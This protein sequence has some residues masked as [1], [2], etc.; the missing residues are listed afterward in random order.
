[1]LHEIMIGPEAPIGTGVCK[2]LDANYRE[3]LF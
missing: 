2:I 1:M 3:D